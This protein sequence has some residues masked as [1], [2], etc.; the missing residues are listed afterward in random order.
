MV[1]TWLEMQVYNSFSAWNFCYSDNL[2]EVK[3][4]LYVT[5]ELCNLKIE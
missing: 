2:Y 1:T 4:N 3:P 5:I